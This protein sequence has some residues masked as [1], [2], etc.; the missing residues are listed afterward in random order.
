MEESYEESR[1]NK[2]LALKEHYGNLPNYYSLARSLKR[3]LILYCGPTNCGKTW[4]ALNK[5]VESD[6]GTYLSP[7]RIL[8][9]E[10][11]EEIE[12]RGKLCSYLTGP[13]R[14]IKADAKFSSSTIQML[15]LTTV[16][17]TVVIDEVQCIADISSGWAYT[18]AVLGAPARNVL[19][20]G[21]LDIVP[22]IKMLAELLGEEL[23]IIELKKLTELIVQNKVTNFKS[24]GPATAIIAFSRRDVLSLKNLIEQ[25]DP[26][27]KVSIIYG[28]LS[29]KVR[30][31]EASRFREGESQNL[32]ST[33]AIAMGLNL[34]IERVIFYTTTKFDGKEERSLTPS[35]I[36]QIGGRAGR[37]GKFPKGYVSAF[38][39]NSLK[40]IQE[41]FAKDL[42]IIEPPFY[43]MPDEFHV[44]LISDALETPRLQTT[45]EAFTELV[46]FDHD[47]I[48]VT[49]DTDDLLE[50]AYIV[51][52]ILGDYELIENKLM[53]ARAP[54]DPANMDMRVA[55]EDMLKAYMSSSEEK[56]EYLFNLDN[57]IGLKPTA[58]SRQLLPAEIRL[59]NLTVYSWL[60]YRFPHVFRQVEKMEKVSEFLSNFIEGCLR[61]QQPS[62][63]MNEFLK[64]QIKPIRK[65]LPKSKADIKKIDVSKITIKKPMSS[66]VQDRPTLE[67]SRSYVR[68]K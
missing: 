25:S 34:P 11:Q 43:V 14:E 54:C 31:E 52:N 40:L 46:S 39:D 47:K 56:L 55:Y 4:N 12:K 28:N 8:A 18:Q 2:I 49:A 6:S 16:V 20:T 37:Y 42:E 10:G 17:D 22:A 58:N 62:D 59:K 7:L 5:L 26:E 3:K 1:K 33:D 21:S 48:F 24:L 13:E 30:K 19:M 27:K 45:I 32:V 41:A 35:E 64:D 36:R 51:D 9:L 60:A 66:N 23:E 63:K 65:D 38:D 50:L 68:Q 44:R 53:L 61:A 67:P 57:W 15:D 29:P